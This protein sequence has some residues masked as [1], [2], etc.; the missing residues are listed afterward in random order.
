MGQFF[1]VLMPTDET[2][3]AISGLSTTV[4]SLF[5]GFLIRYQNFPRF[6]IFMYWLSP[7]HYALEGLVVTQF[8]G[9]STPIALAN[10]QEVTAEEYIKS[11]F[12]AWSYDHVGQNILALCLFI[13]ASW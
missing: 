7:L 13:A 9:D 10:Q 2:V 8:H 4:M 1:S 11:D 12:E 6:W 5:C 3:T